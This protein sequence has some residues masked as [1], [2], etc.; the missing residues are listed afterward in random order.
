MLRPEEQRLTF[1]PAGRPAQNQDVLN[2]P[3]GTSSSSHRTR[4]TAYAPPVCRSNQ[5]M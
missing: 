4:H 3:R 1:A 2:W 5:L